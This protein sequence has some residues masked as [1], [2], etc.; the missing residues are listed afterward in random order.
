L[1]ALRNAINLQPGFGAAHFALG[2]L[3]KASG[4]PNADEELRTAKMLNEL[5]ANSKEKAGPR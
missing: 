4:D 2:I 3:L 1:D 5:A